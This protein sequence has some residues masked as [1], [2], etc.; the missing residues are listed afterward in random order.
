MIEF[1]GIRSDER[2]LIVEHYPKRQ[3]PKLRYTTEV[4]PGRAGALYI[5]ESDDAFDVYT[6]QYSVF[7]DA[8]A[9]GLPMA[10]RG[11]AEWL[12]GSPGF[13]RL[14]DSYDPDFYRLA[15][16]SG[17][18][19]FLNYFNE[20]G[21]GT[22]TFICQPK[23]YYKSGEK[24]L[25]LTSGQKL[26]SPSKFIARPIFEVTG[27]GT[28][29]LSVTNQNGIEKT[30]AITLDNEYSGSV[31]IDAAQHSAKD[32]TNGT[33][34]NNLVTSPYENLNLTQVSTISWTGHIS[35]VKVIPRWWTI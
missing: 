12:L 8:K 23:R 4:V 14:E 10:S 22:L 20:Y 7:L 15:I 21:R 13:Q 28:I 34:F 9:P 32:S 25:T 11:L 6:Q 17:G 30:F 16:Y 19:S 2:Y 35:S 3:F 33:N 5:P 1:A 26:F 18:E 29:T 31:V 27:N 24:K